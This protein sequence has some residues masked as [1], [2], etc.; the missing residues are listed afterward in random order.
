MTAKHRIGTHIRSSLV[1]ITPPLN[2]PTQPVFLYTH[3]QTAVS[4]VK[5]Q[6]KLLSF[7]GPEVGKKM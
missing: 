4:S 1:T 2:N 6:M 3:D 7:G 5:H